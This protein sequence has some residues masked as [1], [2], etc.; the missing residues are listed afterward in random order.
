MAA[1]KDSNEKMVHAIHQICIDSVG[2]LSIKVSIEDTTKSAYIKVQYD[3]P[4]P[5]TTQKE[6]V[7]SAL[8]TLA[9]THVTVGLL[10]VKTEDVS[11]QLLTSE[12]ATF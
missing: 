2:L 12:Y 6:K 7:A 8:A 5:P 10:T 4:L 9:S 1:L 11:V 3:G